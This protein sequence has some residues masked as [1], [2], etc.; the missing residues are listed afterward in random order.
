MVTAKELH[1]G[2]YERL[3]QIASYQG[4]EFTSYE[5]DGYLTR[6]QDA[7]IE[8]LYKRHANML[9]KYSSDLEDI[10][11]KNKNI[12]AYYPQV[13]DSYYEPINA[14][15][16]IK[17][18]DFKYTL[19]V[20]PYI[21][22]GNS[23]TALTTED[24]TIEKYISVVP[25]NKDLLSGLTDAYD[26]IVSY[27]QA[28]TPIVLF[29][30]ANYTLYTDVTDEED[31]HNII[32]LFLAEIN[33]VN[34][35]NL[36]STT[37]AANPANKYKDINLLGIEVY[38]EKYLEYYYP[39]SFIFVSTVVGALSKFME[40]KVDS[41]SATAYNVTATNLA[42]YVVN[43][44][45]ARG[46]FYQKDFV[47][48]TASNGT[49]LYTYSRM[50]DEKKQELRLNEMN[51]PRKEKLTHTEYKDKIS[52]YYPDNVIV[53]SVYLDYIRQPRPISL[54]NN[55]NC[56]LG[57]NLKNDVINRAVELAQLH[58]GDSKLEGTLKVN[59]ILEQ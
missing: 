16:I 46:L 42:Y 14:C 25:F 30:L 2:F 20:K 59:Q 32:N 4:E 55:M 31:K 50:I 1:I 17:P 53:E 21:K 57:Y 8:S 23:C 33:L 58:I 40:I 41:A 37:V 36:T 45:K 49:A 7:L 5:V 3:N 26:F 12:I 27:D 6:G 28:G 19:T 18:V 51:R 39:N 24:D 15:F 54:I 35:T 9:D 44:E 34:R 13:G 11:V 10:I 48:K 56:E 22:Y 29:T 52:L 38:W 47:S 43:L